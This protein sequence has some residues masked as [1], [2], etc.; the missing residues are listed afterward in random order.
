MRRIVLAVVMAAVPLFAADPPKPEA[1][2]K[3]AKKA[4]EEYAAAFVK[5]DVTAMFDHVHENAIKVAG[6]REKGEQF[7]KQT[8]KQGADAGIKAKS[9]A[10]DAPDDLLVEGDNT[11][12]VLPTTAEATSPEGRQVFK[13][14]LLGI[15]ADGGKTWKFVDGAWLLGSKKV[16]EAILPKLPAKLELPE[17]KAP[18]IVKEK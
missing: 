5:G 9:F 18:E 14:Y 12:A 1:A 3:A 16:A 10:V 15:S 13:S 7:V 17:L 8:L 4:A 2:K 6:G 11:F